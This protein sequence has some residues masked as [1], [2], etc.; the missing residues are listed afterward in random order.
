MRAL[1]GNTFQEEGAPEVLLGYM[2][3]AALHC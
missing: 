2:S 1:E 3:S